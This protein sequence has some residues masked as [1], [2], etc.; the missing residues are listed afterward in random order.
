M[1]VEFVGG[2]DGIDVHDTA[3]SSVA[4]KNTEAIVRG[5]QADLCVPIRNLRTLSLT[6]R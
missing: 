1:W 2:F 3:V 5:Q 4:S 6:E